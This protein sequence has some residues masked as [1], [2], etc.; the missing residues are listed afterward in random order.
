MQF[1]NAYLFICQQYVRFLGQF[2][3]F[4]PHIL[5]FGVFFDILWRIKNVCMQIIACS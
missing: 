1:F 3:H 5:I 2:L 4:V